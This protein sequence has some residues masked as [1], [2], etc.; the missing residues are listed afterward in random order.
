EAEAGDADVVDHAAGA[1]AGAR[2]GADAGV[3]RQRR[4]DDDADV[5]ALAQRRQRRRG[6]GETGAG[7]I[8]VL[9]GTS[10]S[11]RRS[12]QPILRGSSEQATRWRPGWTSRP[13][14]T[15]RSFAPLGNLR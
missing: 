6:R 3:D 1:L 13:S 14:R 10:S 15:T 5:V 12:T 11:T 7:A 4:R 8:G 2:A 9:H